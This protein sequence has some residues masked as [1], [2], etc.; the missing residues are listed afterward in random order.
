VQSAGCRADNVKEEL[1][2]KGKLSGKGEWSGM[3]VIPD[4][5]PGSMHCYLKNSYLRK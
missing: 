4:S 2:G 1:K 3:A 5:D